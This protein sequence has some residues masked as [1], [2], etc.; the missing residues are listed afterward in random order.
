MSKYTFYEDPGH[1]WLKVPMAH[2]IALGIAG[3]IT[4][5]SYRDDTHAYL[6]EDCDLST[7]LA[8]A[9]LDEPVDD[10]GTPVWIKAMAALSEKREEV[11]EF[12]DANVVVNDRAT[13][14]H[15]PEIF[16]RRLPSYSAKPFK[17]AA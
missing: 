8:A 10:Y 6:E 1:G 5:C 9:V 4:S 2:L 11:K 13:L 14:I 15:A 16:I 12:W 17:R 3:V 7:F